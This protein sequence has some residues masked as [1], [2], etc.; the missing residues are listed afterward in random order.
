MQSQV[1]TL[2][3]QLSHKFSFPFAVLGIEC[4]VLHISEKCSTTELYPH[5]SAMNLTY[6]FTADKVKGRHI[7][8]YNSLVHKEDMSVTQGW[9]GIS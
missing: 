5:P 3:L 2:T 6:S 9:P 8:L 7:Q 4:R 1:H